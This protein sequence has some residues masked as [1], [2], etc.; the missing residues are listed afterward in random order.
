MW[1][2][3]I[4][5]NREAEERPSTASDLLHHRIVVALEKK[6]YIYNFSD[7]KL[8]DEFPSCTNPKGM[9]ALKL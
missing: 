6:V 9:Y 1:C 3:S 5:R 8:L 7:L 2:E 4:R